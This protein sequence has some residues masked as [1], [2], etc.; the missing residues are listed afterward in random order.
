ML[1]AE[2]QAIMVQG[3]ALMSGRAGFKSPLPDPRF[4]VR[5]EVEVDRLPRRKGRRASAGRNPGTGGSPGD[6]YAVPR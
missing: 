1:S 6:E 4:K 3:E 5:R 2:G